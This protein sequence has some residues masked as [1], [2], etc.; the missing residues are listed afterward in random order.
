[1]I[2]AIMGFLWQCLHRHQQKNFQVHLNTVTNA[3]P[4]PVPTCTY[5]KVLVE[6]TYQWNCRTL[7]HMHTRTCMCGALC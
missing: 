7:L 5:A 3:P 1:M 2:V 6:P 4:P